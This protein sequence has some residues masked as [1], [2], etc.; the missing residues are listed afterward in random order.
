MK[1]QNLSR[2]VDYLVCPHCHKDRLVKVQNYFKCTSCKTQYPIIK[3]IPI[4]VSS[5]K[6]SAIIRRWKS[7]QD[8][9]GSYF[10]LNKTSRIKSPLEKSSKKKFALDI[11]CGAGTYSD[12]FKSGSIGFNII[13]Y[14][15]EIALSR[16]KDP[17][18]IF[19]IA[20]AHEFPFE[21]KVF[22]LAYCGSALEHFP[23]EKSE[24]LIRKILESSRDLIVVDVPNDSTF[25]NRVFRKAIE[26]FY[27]PE[28]K[29]RSISDICSEHPH[30]RT[31]TLND[32][33]KFGFKCYG[34]IGHVTRTGIN[35]PLFWD[36]YDKIV[37]RHPLFAGTLIGI[38]EQKS[39]I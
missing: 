31:F 3:N 6:Q 33:K 22:D 11:C 1:S 9:Q 2:L 24:E 29:R 34:C 27:R 23:K 21:E 8:K 10:N 35:F 14:F 19:C 15:I 32:L 39:V 4:V 37:F 16:N 30:L 5:K 25:I 38:K 20:D 12:C 17:D 7:K 28:V 18:N 26:A 13:P 36:I